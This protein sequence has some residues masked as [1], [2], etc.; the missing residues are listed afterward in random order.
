MKKYSIIKL[1][2]ILIGFA[3][4]SSIVSYIVTGYQTEAA[5][6]RPSSTS[7]IV[8]IYI[9]I[10]AFVLGILGASAGLILGI[11]LRYIFKITTVSIKTMFILMLSAVV[12][13]AL[14]GING[15]YEVKSSVNRNR[16]HVVYSDGTILK[17]RVSTEPAVKK[18]TSA[19]RI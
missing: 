4:A 10:A 19:H 3:A 7:S 18:R 9:P 5:I 12:A 1:L 17:Q 8:L 11:I 6:G 16:P 13:V 15:H 14:S 2:P